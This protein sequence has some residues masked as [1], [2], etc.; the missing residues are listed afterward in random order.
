MRNPSLRVAGAIACCILWAGWVFA[1]APLTTPVS[2]V[3]P[4]QR[5]VVHTVFA[6]ADIDTFEAEIVGTLQSGRTQGDMILARATTP[7]VIHSGIAQGMSGSPVYVNGRL[8][9]ALSSGWAFSRDPLFGITPIAEMLELWNRPLAD[10]TD[11][12]SAGPSG[13]DDL[14]LAAVPRYGELRWAGDEDSAGSLEQARAAARVTPASASALTPSRLP[15]P[16]ACAGLDSRA[17]AVASNWLAPFHLTVIPGG[18]TPASR[19]GPKTLEPGSAVAVEVLRGDLEFSAIGT[20]TWRDGDRVLLFGHPFFQAGGVRMPMATADI[21]TIVA[22]EQMSFKLGARGREVG[23]VVQDRRPGVS[24]RMGAV[25]RMLPFR[26]DVRG[27]STAPQHFRFETIR[28]R[29]LAPTLVSVAALNAWLESGGG[30]ANQTLRW[31]LRLHR[32]GAAPLEIHDVAAGDS[33]PNEVAGAVMA[34][35]RFLF[36]NPFSALDLDSIGVSIA[37]EP[38]RETWTLRS[39]RILEPAVRPGDSAHVVCEIERWRGPRETV[40]LAVGVPGEAPDGR[41]TLW[42]GGAAELARYEAQRLPGR[43][44]VTSLDDAWTRLA[45]ARSS[46]A[47]YAELYARA[48]EVN[49]EGRDYPELP[50]SAAP[51]FGGDQAAADRGRRGDIAV[52]DEHRIPMDGKLLGELTLN[53]VVERNRP[54]GK[55]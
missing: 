1:A 8:I 27:A 2:E 19:P 20:V 46:D 40:R 32:H 37:A 17:G 34:P 44:R 9:G 21:V 55:P 3:R 28:D 39:A 49:L 16:L 45:S 5:A 42:L 50:G 23:A 30:G 25:A 11:D 51:L 24:G 15:L 43:Y 13:S 31:S 10:S 48:S 7:R 12:E 22:S 52:L 47:L 54:L 4:G 53:V 29:S 35:L 6:G 14:G 33:P 41:Y 18:R 38:G 26:V 36:S